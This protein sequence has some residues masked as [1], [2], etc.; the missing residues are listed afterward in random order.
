MKLLIVDDHEVVRMGLRTLLEGQGG[1]DVIGEAATAAKAVKMALAKKP[2]VVLMDVRL[3]DESGIEACRQIRSQN[4]DIQVLML[5]SY[6]NDEAIFAAIMAGASGYLL[7]QIDAEHLYH[8]VSAVGRGESI[9]DA[10]VSKTI[11]ERVKAISEGG[12][13]RGMDS[14]SERE[15]EILRLIAEGLTNKEIAEKI[16]LG[17]K[18]VRNYVSSIL[19]KLGISHRTQAAVY[20]LKRLG[21]DKEGF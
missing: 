6:S 1:L 10:T 14:L 15:K 7:K 18:T 8:A 12:P 11:V 21:L 13:S 9:L 2:D 19:L 4:P 3:P 16:C 17:E 20:Y 5:T